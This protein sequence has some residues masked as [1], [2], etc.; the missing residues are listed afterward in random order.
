MLRGGLRGPGPG[1][2]GTSRRVA[3]NG[4]VV[5]MILPQGGQQL[6]AWLC[7]W[8]LH[9]SLLAASDV[10]CGRGT[11]NENDGMARRQA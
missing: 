3:M 9:W 7:M 1:H 11:G 10:L 5:V 8:S 6:H 2:V 4:V